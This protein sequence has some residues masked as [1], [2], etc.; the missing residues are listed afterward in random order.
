MSNLEVLELLKSGKITVSEAAQTLQQF[1]SA[2]SAPFTMKV[3]EKGALTFRGVP[4]T[5]HL[6]GLSIYAKGV[7]FLFA[8]KAQIEAFI[9]AN[10]A[11]LSWEKKTSAAAA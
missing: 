5:H 10:H 4:G 8:H 7:E 9:K 2:P 11:K 1:S 6:F 3:S